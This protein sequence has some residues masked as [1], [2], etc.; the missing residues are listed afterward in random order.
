MLV[1][2]D[3]QNPAITPTQIEAIMAKIDTDYLSK[4]VV[5]EGVEPE[6]VQIIVIANES[7]PVT[8]SQYL[9]YVKGYQVLLY[10]AAD[11]DLYG[12]A[13]TT[14]ITLAAIH[15]NNK[16]SMFI[17]VTS[18][19]KSYQYSVPLCASYGIKLVF[20]PTEL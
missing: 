19:A 8:T 7:T 10:P 4:R 2:L 15:T 5:S 3:L 20:V 9:R 17:M 1:Y 18:D 16:H 14:D 13:I 11:S 12:C 6:G